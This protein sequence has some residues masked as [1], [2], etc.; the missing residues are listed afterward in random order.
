MLFRSLSLGQP[1]ITILPIGGFYCL[2]ARQA[3]ETI[4][5]LQPKKASILCH[6]LYGPLLTRDDFQGMS[7]EAPFLALKGSE[8]QTLMTSFDSE[9]SYKKYL[10]FSPD[11]LNKGE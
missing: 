10:I 3:L 6:Y 7:T 11:L 5:L 2:D 9:N 8:T 4:S 1:D